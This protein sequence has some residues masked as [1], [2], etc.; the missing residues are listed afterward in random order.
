MIYLVPRL[1]LCN[2][3]LFF[4]S[5]IYLLLSW[6]SC[7]ILDNRQEIRRDVHIQFKSA[8]ALST[9]RTVEDITISLKCLEDAGIALST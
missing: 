8:A 2:I 5:R 6:S 9:L 7:G 4:I 3:S 1:L